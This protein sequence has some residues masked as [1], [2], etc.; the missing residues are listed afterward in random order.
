M[1][2]TNR[3]P[4][5]ADPWTDWARQHEADKAN[6]RTDYARTHG[7]EAFRNLVDAYERANELRTTVF[8]LLALEP[9]ALELLFPGYGAA[10]IDDL[11]TVQRVLRMLTGGIR[12][13]MAAKG[14]DF[15]RCLRHAPPVVPT[16]DALNVTDETPF[17]NDPE[18]GEQI[19]ARRHAERELLK[20]E[21]ESH[22]SG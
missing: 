20:S 11:L 6:Y 5:S 13:A 10:V 15:A 3:I 14:P 9:Y 18:Y 4:Q 8:E 17:L 22:A 12:E 19:S 16:F 1:N 2:R 7:P 21:R